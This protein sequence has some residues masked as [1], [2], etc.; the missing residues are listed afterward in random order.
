MSNVNNA[1]ISTTNTTNVRLDVSKLLIKII[2]AHGNFNT[3]K[4]WFNIDRYQNIIENNNTR[5]YFKNI[6]SYGWKYLYIYLNSNSNP[7]TTKCYICNKYTYIIRLSCDKG[8]CNLPRFIPH[9]LSVCVHCIVKENMPPTAPSCCFKEII[10][11]KSANK[12]C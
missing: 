3:D 7:A 11:V 2:T 1:I 4:K 12:R 10:M 8:K 5:D 6:S 9:I